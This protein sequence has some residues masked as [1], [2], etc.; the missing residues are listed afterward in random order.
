MFISA[1]YLAE[2]DF[3]YHFGLTAGELMYPT[4][5]GDTASLISNVRLAL[6]VVGYL[7]EQVLRADPAMEGS[8]S[9]RRRKGKSDN[10]EPSV[11]VSVNK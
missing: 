8:L 9:R 3:S 2:L 5:Q 1:S 10:R 6:G 7:A 11:G 4:R